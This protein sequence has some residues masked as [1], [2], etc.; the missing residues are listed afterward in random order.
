MP[1]TIADVA[2]LIRSKNAGPFWVTFDIMMEDEETYRMVRDRKV[3]TPELI[4]RLYHQPL[5]HVIVVAHDSARAIKISIPRP[6]STGAPEDT[7]P[8]MG[9]QY[10]PLLDLIVEP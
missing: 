1:K 5:E 9:Q 10:A 2:V 6:C 3:I 8:H 4:A 7:D